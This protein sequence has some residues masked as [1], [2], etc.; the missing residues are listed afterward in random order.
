MLAKITFSL[1]ATSPECD[2]L[3]S[4]IFR[5]N[6]MAERFPVERVRYGYFVLEI[7]AVQFLAYR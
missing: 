2:I 1:F 7:D 3:L 6:P 5:S 4:I